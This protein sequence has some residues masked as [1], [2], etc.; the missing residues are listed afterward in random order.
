MMNRIIRF[1]QMPEGVFHGSVFCQLSGSMGPSAIAVDSKGNLYVAQFEPAGKE[2]YHHNPTSQ[3]SF[4]SLLFF[5]SSF[6][7]VILLE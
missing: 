5:F 7:L 4:L 3:A 2:S 6:D 1:I